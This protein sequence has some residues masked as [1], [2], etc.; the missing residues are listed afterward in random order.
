VDAKAPAAAFEAFL[1]S[2]AAREI[3][4]RYG[5]KRLPLVSLHQTSAVRFKGR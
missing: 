4:L 3:F 2:D 1:E 5:F